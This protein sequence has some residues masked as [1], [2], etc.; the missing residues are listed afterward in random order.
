MAGLGSAG[1]RHSAVAGSVERSNHTSGLTK[2]KIVLVQQFDTQFFN[3]EYVPW[4]RLELRSSRVRQLTLVQRD[5]KFITSTESESFSLRYL[6]CCPDHWH[7][8]GPVCLHAHNSSP[9]WLPAFIVFKRAYVNQWRWS[10]QW[11]VSTKFQME[12]LWWTCQVVNQFCEC[13]LE[14]HK[15]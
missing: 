12:Y 3:K 7:Q 6:F 5:K 11:F 15:R 13:L 9:S 1:S 2:V 14:L 4:E 8:H 10:L